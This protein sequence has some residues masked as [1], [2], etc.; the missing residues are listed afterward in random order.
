MTLKE[1][2][3]LRA[4]TYMKVL[5]VNLNRKYPI[6]LIAYN[7]G[8]I[9]FKFNSTIYPTRITEN[10]IGSTSDIYGRNLNCSNNVIFLYNLFS[11]KEIF[12]KMSSFS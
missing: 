4:K 12:R 9:K 10:Y 2:F 6:S 7:Y 1:A 5:L 3:Y 11:L 8:F